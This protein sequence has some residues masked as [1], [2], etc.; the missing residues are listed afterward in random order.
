M[1]KCATSPC[2]ACSPKN[3]CDRTESTERADIA[4]RFGVPHQH[5][6][7]GHR[8]EA[9]VIPDRSIRSHFDQTLTLSIP[10]LNF[11]SLPDRAPVIKNLLKRGETSTDQAWPTHS[12]H[13]A[14][15]CGAKKPC[16]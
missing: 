2:G 9:G 12:T 10:V 14:R 7:D 11:P 13:C 16:I 1:P 5:P 15:R 3:I 8:R 6:T 4:V